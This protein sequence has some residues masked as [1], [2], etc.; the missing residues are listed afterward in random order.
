MYFVALLFVILL[1]RVSQDVDDLVEHQDPYPAL[2]AKLANVLPGNLADFRAPHLSVRR[3]R[4]E[5][6]GNSNISTRSQNLGHQIRELTDLA[7]V[8]QRV[9]IDV[10]KV[11]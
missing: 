3:I 1:K 8:G 6:I 5:F 11:A 10:W 7:A 9:D 2:L 4:R